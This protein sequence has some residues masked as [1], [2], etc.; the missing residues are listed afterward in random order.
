[1]SLQHAILGILEFQ[2]MHG[3]E[4]RR[5]LAEGISTFWPV[6]LPAIYPSLRR[7]EEQGWVA[8]RTQPTAQG[9]PDRKVYSIAESGRVELARWRRLA[10]EGE[11]AI[12]SPLYLK[13]FFAKAENL[14]D[15]AEWIG[16]ALEEGHAATDQLRAD[17]S[18]PNVF[19]TFFVRFM[20]ESALAH[21]ELQ[22]EL[23]EGLR[24]RIRVQLAER[25]SPREPEATS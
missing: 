21:F 4:L 24:E 1:M 23:L 16:K 5:V 22:T 9:R 6:N 2:P 15:A 7:L 11:A 13:L 3:Y 10:P 14:P 18:N 17:L 12:R 19:S 8:H 25:E 20:R